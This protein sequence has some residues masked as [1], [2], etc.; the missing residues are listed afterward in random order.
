ML[1]GVSINILISCR[2]T[3]RSVFGLATPRDWMTDVPTNSH[4]LRRCSIIFPI[5]SSALGTNL[6]PNVYIK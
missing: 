5:R 3:S 4:S 2:E 6:G 1:R